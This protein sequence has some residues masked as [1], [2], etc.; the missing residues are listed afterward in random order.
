MS[1]VW[2]S[3]TSTRVARSST[4]RRSTFG[5]LWRST[6]RCKGARSCS[7]SH[8]RPSQSTAPTSTRAK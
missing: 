2:R 5:R 4:G 8:A 3:R 1:R 7:S 6:M